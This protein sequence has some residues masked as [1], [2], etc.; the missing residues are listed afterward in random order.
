M[1]MGLATGDGVRPPELRCC[2]AVAWISRCSPRSLFSSRSPVGSRCS[3]QS[4][5]C[6]MR[7][8]TTPTGRIRRVRPVSRLGSSI[9]GVARATSLCASSPTY[10]VLRSTRAR[11]VPP[12]ASSS[13]SHS[14]SGCS[15]VRSSS[16]LSRPRWARCSCAAPTASIC[17]SRSC[18]RPGFASG[19]RPLRLGLRPREPARRGVQ[20]TA[21]RGLVRGV[22]LSSARS[23]ARAP[24]ELSSAR[25]SRHPDAVLAASRVKFSR[26]GERAV[27]D[28]RRWREAQ[29]VRSHPIDGGHDPRVEH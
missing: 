8:R 17:R 19:S 9:C 13:S 27:P 7:S 24:P 18:V 2:G 12:G 23:A 14:I 28:E 29:R 26:I 16:S 21:A 11:A 1:R 5:R 6:C 25:L 3:S 15:S 20:G 4:P 10:C 22:D